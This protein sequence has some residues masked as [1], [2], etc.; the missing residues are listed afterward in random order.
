MLE[1]YVRGVRF[2]VWSAANRIIAYFAKYS[3][4]M[5]SE[6][7]FYDQSCIDI[8]SWLFVIILER[9]VTKYL[10]AI[11]VSTCIVYCFHMH[12]LVMKTNKE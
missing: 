4:K 6:K 5:H 11:S 12:Y 10:D 2:R 1:R 8:F 3:K 7:D 9:L